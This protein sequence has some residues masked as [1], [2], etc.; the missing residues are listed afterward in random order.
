MSIDLSSGRSLSRPSEAIGSGRSPSRPDSAKAAGLDERE[1]KR[2]RDACKDFEAL[3][4]SSLMKAM[5]KTVEKSSLFGS[6]SGGET[7]QE[8]MDMEVSRSAAN[9]SSMG[10][11]D[12]LYRQATSQLAKQ[13]AS[14]LLRQAQDA[15]ERG[16]DQ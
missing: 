4:L 13:D 14:S 15:Q 7:F 3:F 1:D 10:I 12:M 11:A 8:M 2:L 9:T 5:R 16:D 6:D